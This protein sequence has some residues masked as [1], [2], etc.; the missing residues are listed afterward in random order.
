MGM[1]VGV[2]LLSDLFFYIF[3]ILYCVLFSEYMH[4]IINL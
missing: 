3:N 4:A 2:G 1:G